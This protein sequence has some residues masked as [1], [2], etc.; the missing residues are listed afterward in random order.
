MRHARKRDRKQQ[1]EQLEELAPRAEAGTRER[2]LEK[3]RETRDKMRAF[4]DGKS[5]GAG[6]A[7]AVGDKELLGA[8]EDDGIDAYRAK[9]KEQQRKKNERELRK[10]EILRVCQSAAI[11]F[12]LI[13]STFSIGPQRFPPP[14]LSLSLSSKFFIYLPLSRPIQGLFPTTYLWK[15]NPHLTKER[16]EGEKK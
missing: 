12:Y 5:P 8:G 11:L 13:F 7:D 4:R 3:R 2:Q 14:S 6:D 10:E 9:K 16:E 1:R 15:K